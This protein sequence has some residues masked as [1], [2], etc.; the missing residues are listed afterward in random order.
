VFAYDDAITERFPT[1]RAGVTH[2]TG[3]S[4]GPSPPELLDEYRAE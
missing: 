1:I 3:P 2:A 4:N